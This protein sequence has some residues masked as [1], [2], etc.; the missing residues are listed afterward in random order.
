L[1]LPGAGVI[2]VT[3]LKAVNEAWLPGYMAQS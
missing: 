3:E 2:S 1:T